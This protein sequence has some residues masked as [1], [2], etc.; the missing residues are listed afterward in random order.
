MQAEKIETDPFERSNVHRDLD[1]GNLEVYPLLGYGAVATGTHRFCDSRKD[2]NCL[3]I[4]G[5]AKFVTLWQHTDAGW[6][7]TRVISYYHH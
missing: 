5:P 7:I 4:G 3:T 2:T 6:N 1:P